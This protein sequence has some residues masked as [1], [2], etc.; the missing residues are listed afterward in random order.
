[1]VGWLRKG[2]LLLGLGL[3]GTL[4]WGRTLLRL[5]LML[6]SAEPLRGL[7]RRCLLRRAS[8]GES[9][10]CTSIGAARQVVGRLLLLPTGLLREALTTPHVRL[11]RSLLLCLGV[12]G[13]LAPLL[14]IPSLAHVGGLLPPAMLPCGAGLGRAHIGRPELTPSPLLRRVLL[15]HVPTMLL[16]AHLC[17]TL[18]L[19]P[20]PSLGVLVVHGLVHHILLKL[21]VHGI[22]HIHVLV[23]R[24]PLQAGVATILCHHGRVGVAHQILQGGQ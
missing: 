17:T 7:L 23:G 22:G 11:P 6:C 16:V 3:R 1:M 12:H 24:C 10:A 15:P 4:L 19:L 2:L 18:L 21:V 8:L 13:M 14:A 5:P 20:H 9:P